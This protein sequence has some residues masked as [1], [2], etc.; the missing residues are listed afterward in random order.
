M[1]HNGLRHFLDLT[2]I[3]A[4]DLRGILEASSALKGRIKKNGWVE[5]KPLAGKTLA[6]S[7]CAS[8]AARACY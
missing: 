3:P 8:S 2:E 6:T 5:A 1:S 4:Q 7:P